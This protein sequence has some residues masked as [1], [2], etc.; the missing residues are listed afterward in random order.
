MGL[1]RLS[2][3][4]YIKRENIE[5]TQRKHFELPNLAMSRFPW[6]FRLGDFRIPA[7]FL[8]FFLLGPSLLIGT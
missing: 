2:G 4:I 6:D 5:D 7:L 1:V 3:C 8:R